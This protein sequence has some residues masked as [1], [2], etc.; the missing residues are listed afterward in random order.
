MGRLRKGAEADLTAVARIVLCDWQRGKISYFN[1]PP[2]FDTTNKEK[3]E[4]KKPVKVV[5]G[6]RELVEIDQL[7]S[8]IDMSNSES[9]IEGSSEEESLKEE[10]LMEEG[11]SS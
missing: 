1:K 7:D 11:D 6:R 4:S 8:E 10:D 5:E 9:D 3:V 2:I